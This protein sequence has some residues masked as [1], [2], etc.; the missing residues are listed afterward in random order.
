MGRYQKMSTHELVAK[1]ADYRTAHVL[2]L[3]LS[4]LSAGLW[5]LIWFFVAISHR[6]ERNK[7]DREL[8]SR[9]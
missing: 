5:L 7:I 8:R 6:N 9:E 1:R 3:L 4:V 2:H